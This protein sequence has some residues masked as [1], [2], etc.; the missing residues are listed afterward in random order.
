MNRIYQGR[1]TRI[2]AKK[3]D[4]TFEQVVFGQDQ[5]SCPLWRHHAI[6]QDAVNYYL[7]ALASLAKEHISGAD[8]LMTDLPKR[9]AAAW[10]TFPKP[11]AARAG[12]RSLRDSVA[13]WIDLDGSATIDRAYEAILDGNTI[14]KKA[15]SYALALVL[16]ECSGDSGIQQ[17]GREYLP[18]LCD[19]DSK[20][21]YN[22]SA[23]SVASGEGKGRLAV[24]LHGDG[25]QND[26]E[27]I[28][29]EMDL[30]WVV[31]VSPGEFYEGA[32][33]IT[34]LNQAIDHLALMA[35]NPSE[36]LAAALADIADVSAQINELRGAMKLLPE[37][38]RIARNRKAA[39]DLTFSAI[40]FM[41]FP[42]RLTAAFLKLGI[43]APAK[44]EISTKKNDAINF[45]VLG[46]DPVRIARGDR[47]FVFR[48]FTALPRWNPANPGKQAWKEF[49]IAAFKEALKALN[50][51]RLKTEER[52]DKKKDLEGLIAYLIGSPIKG[53]K[54]S[55]EESGEETELP[56][57]LDPV[58]LKL[59]W[60]LEEEMTQGLSESVV[61]EMKHLSFGEGSLPI[62][63]GGWTVTRASLRGLRDIV[64]GWRRLISKHGADVC[65]SDLED[66]VKE[67]QGKE[68]K[69]AVIG[70]VSL[71]LTL[72]EPKFR[73]LWMDAEHEEGVEADDNRFLHRL[74]DLHE[75]VAD[76]QKCDEAINLTPAEPRHSRRL[77]MFSDM[78]GKSAPEYQGVDSLEVSMATEGDCVRQRRFRLRF[79][80]PR[81]RRDG[82]LGSEDGWLQPV[83]KA[84][85]LKLSKPDPSPFDSAVSLMP[86]F[87]S[88]GSLRFLL[89]FAADVDAEPI[90]KALG[91]SSLWDR[92]FNGTKDK[93]IH[94]HW[95]V[96]VDPAKMKV[97]PWCEN[98]AII[99]KGFTVMATDLGQRTAG[100]W[101]LLRITA[102]EPMTPRPV[103]SIGHDGK[104]EWF[105][106]IL[107][108][109]MHRLPGEDAMTRGKDGHMRQELSG[110]TG[111]MASEDE[112]KETLE[113]AKALLA[114][115]PENWI[116]TN[117]LVKSYPE[118]N[119]AL[120]RLANRR[121][122]RLQTFH[123]WSC[124]DPEKET[125]PLR[126]GSLIKKLIAELDKWEDDEVAR[127]A[128]N[129]HSGDI[130]AFRSAAGS[131]FAS[132][133]ADLLTHLVSLANRVAPLREDHWGWRQRGG[134][135]PYGDL[136]RIPRGEGAK[137]PVRGQRG[138]SLARI[139][140]MENLRRLFL[141][142]NRALDREAGKPAKFGLADTGRDSGEPCRDLLEK[143]DRIKEQ[144][145][146]QTAHLIL[147]QA[148]GVK[149]APHGLSAQVRQEGDHHGE[150]TRISGREPVDLVVI[151]DL[152]RYLSSQGRAPSENSRL[153][154]WAHRAVRDK[155]KMLIEEPFG[156]P[157]LEVPAA[158]SSRFCAV[159][160]EAGARCEERAELDD[161][162]REILERR[163]VTPA[164][165]GQHDLREANLRLLMQFKLLDSINASRRAAGKC[166][167]TLLLQKTGGPLFVGAGE[168]SRLV[169][170]DMNAAINLAFRAIAAPE[171][172]HLL[173]RIR[174]EKTGDQIS[175][176]AKNRRE[177]AVFG[178]KGLP[179]SIEGEPSTKLS[180]SANFFHDPAGI[181]KF[182]RG[183]I[184][185]GGKTIPVA[186]GI[187]LWH[188]V[189]GAILPKIVAINEDR[190]RR[191]GLAEAGKHSEEAED[192]I[193]M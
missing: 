130:T 99:E 3:E 40:V 154:K 107:K 1:V 147:A 176:L 28:A 156:I 29:L 54:P 132:Y 125:D 155:V 72:C 13:P 142:Y 181:A 105:A 43:K 141:R 168:Q 57:V 152:G 4:G 66:E 30:S 109:G 24:T 103:R 186:S 58:L 45:G 77:F 121:L 104:H 160:G 175:T 158:Y 86:D 6:F 161:Y 185:L 65:A 63:E 59:A 163:S 80:A 35:T 177:I 182:D 192:N 5:S 165:F 145:V 83:T 36:R 41:A 39:P 129:L 110:K 12:A 14:D 91:K 17:G 101:A 16:D 179:I 167:A 69:S 9:M 23:S 170:S 31:K 67:Y 96:T 47:G 136:V 116:G 119:D 169:Q 108:T 123:R 166:P 134:D 148:L 78:P 49:D 118:Q 44:S 87:D 191:Y 15:L 180:K 38:Y 159:T 98:P 51:F 48:A 34:R 33:A 124:F 74:A 95:P 68:G 7:M 62:R 122:S 64:D 164:A 50:Q 27:K 70:S 146:D 133:R 114:E 153:M 178:K 190:L 184:T 52:E 97:S 60:D 126:K 173:H 171:S 93:S 32:E 127:W 128:G 157:V 115:E 137:P 79:K 143:I 2:E 46:D 188:A 22:F 10:E 56:E 111:R 53:W 25:S 112:W 183:E 88:S 26:L 85:G 61:G 42:S 73:P 100:S 106:E 71:F 113:L 117:R 94:L 150:Y 174:S 81:L 131:A 135:S 187:G 76:Y 8:R 21:T 90:R 102:T 139:E 138:L 92:Q 75:S 18:K 193:P 120:L 140:Q 189:N 144:R 82:L 89:N 20:A 55:K 37:G 162:V 172:L 151:E 19:S 84:L 11:D 149:L